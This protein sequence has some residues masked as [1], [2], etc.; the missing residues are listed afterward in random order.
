MQQAL[1]Q[2]LQALGTAPQEEPSRGWFLL[3]PLTTL[4]LVLSGDVGPLLG[5]PVNLN[6]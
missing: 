6:K 2:V 3:T 4:R 5:A 1:Q